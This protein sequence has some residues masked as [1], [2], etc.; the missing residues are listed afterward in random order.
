VLSHLENGDELP[1]CFLERSRSPS[2]RAFEVLSVAG[3][4]VDWRPSA[5]WLMSFGCSLRSYLSGYQQQPFGR[6]IGGRLA[7]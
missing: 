5:D 1:N 6:F 3:A 4:I 7:G 2:Y